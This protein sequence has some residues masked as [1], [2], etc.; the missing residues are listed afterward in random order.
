MQDNA[1]LQKAI[2]KYE[3]TLQEMDAIF[4]SDERDS[5]IFDLKR[6]I[7]VQLKELVKLQREADQSK[8]SQQSFGHDKKFEEET[9]KFLKQENEE[10]K[11]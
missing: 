5:V 6:L 7:E 4:R 2:Y 10:L 8:N 3:T 11:Q 1:L 9:I